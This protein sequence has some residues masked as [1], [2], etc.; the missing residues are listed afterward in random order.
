MKKNKNSKLS[1]IDSED[2][3]FSHIGDVSAKKFLYLLDKK[4]N[5]DILFENKKAKVKKIEPQNFLHEKEKDQYDDLYEKEEYEDN[6]FDKE[7][8]I[9][10]RKELKEKRKK[11]EPPKNACAFLQETIQLSKPSHKKKINKIKREKD[12]G[13]TK[14]E[15]EKNKIKKEGGENKVSKKE[16]IEK[17][18]LYEL[19]N[20]RYK[21]HLIHHHHDLFVDKSI[22]NLNEQVSS[23]SYK[24]KLEYIFKKIIYSPEFN[25][26]SGRYDQEKKRGI[27]KNK[28]EIIMK[29]QKEKEYESYQKQLKKIRNLKIFQKMKNETSENEVE[30]ER[31]LNRNRNRYKSINENEH[32]TK[33][34]SENTIFRRSSLEQQSEN[35]SRNFNK[36]FYK[37]NNSET[38]E[39]PKYLDID[40]VNSNKNK[41]NSLAYFQ[42]GAEYIE[43]DYNRIEKKK[44]NSNN[45]DENTLSSVN[46]NKT[47]SGKKKISNYETE[48]IYPNVSKNESNI[49][50]NNHYSY[51]KSLKDQKAYST[52]NNLNYLINLK[53][54]ENIS[55]NFPFNFNDINKKNGNNFSIGLE[56]TRLLPSHKVVNFEK[57]LSR[58]YFKKLNEQEKNTYSSISPN[59]DTIMP[60]CIMKVVYA[61]K[62]YKK[63]RTK[64]FKSDYNQIVFDIDKSYNKYNNHFPPKNI[65]FGKMTG[66]K[67][68][69]TLPSYMLDQYNRNAFNTFNDKSFK[70]NNFSN[71]DLLEQRSSFN[72]KRTFNFKLNDQYMG[73]EPNSLNKELDAIFRKVTRYPISNKK[74][75]YGELRSNSC[76]SSENQNIRYI[77]FLNQTVMRTKL[78]EYYQVNLDKFGKYPF[79][80]GE[81][82]DGFTMKTIKSS[83]SSLNLLS[84]HEKRIFL[85]KLDS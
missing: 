1:Q 50:I 65:F 19:E 56:K 48:V 72:Q 77:N 21:Y 60:K 28:K 45:L 42:N 11:Y 10:Y 47:T 53:K 15:K 31:E 71:G 49:L 63:N 32:L 26:M 33:N 75:T 84:E 30:E 44:N 20:D 54:S 46:Q 59:Y 67:I 14:K 52:L 41:K 25:K 78:P 66:R 24:P 55:G 64:E 13:K 34:N 9:K 12:E 39:E 69:N 29:N 18:L 23:S 22:F 80:C 35:E 36:K 76:S 17:K 27:N 3:N 70:M 16:E 79:S 6:I 7:Y 5:I 73:N 68:D 61:Q 83:K 38:T 57:M 37:R 40:L 58:D 85:S 62:Y 43:N 4:K 2:F 81:K 51:R 8:D 74:N 82:I